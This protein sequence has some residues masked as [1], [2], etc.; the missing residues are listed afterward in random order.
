M[1]RSK[2]DVK[3]RLDPAIE[4]DR[5]EIF[6]TVFHSFR[7]L[8]KVTPLA[9]LAKLEKRGVVLAPVEQPRPNREASHE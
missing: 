8:H 4:D 9:L 6:A 1:N 5:I 3:A 2:R 7:D